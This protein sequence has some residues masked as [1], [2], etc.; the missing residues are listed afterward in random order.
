MGKMGEQQKWPR[1][2]TL[3]ERE[4]GKGKGERGKGKGE[5]VGAGK[6]GKLN[7]HH[8]KQP[9]IALKTKCE[10]WGKCAK[11]GKGEKSQRIAS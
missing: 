1:K 8:T 3:W 11:Q 5:K 2:N 6:V 4:R 7:D 10:T 9:Y